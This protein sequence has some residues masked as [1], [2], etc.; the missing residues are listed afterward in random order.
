MRSLQGKYIL[1]LT[2]KIP[3][4]WG[5]TMLISKHKFVLSFNDIFLNLMA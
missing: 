4:F 5:K 1:T 2:E 3:L